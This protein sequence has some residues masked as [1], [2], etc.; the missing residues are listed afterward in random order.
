MMFLMTMHINYVFTRKTILLIV[1]IGLGKLGV[2]LILS[3][4][5]EPA[6]NRILYRDQYAFDYF[7]EGLTMIK[8]TLLILMLYFAIRLFKEAPYDVV[9]VQR[10]NRYKLFLSKWLVLLGIMV[11]W[12][13][14]F[15]SYFWMIGLGVHRSVTALFTADF[16]LKMGV[17]IL[18][19]SIICPL[20]LVRFQH[21]LPL[22]FIVVGFLV[23]DL[24]VDFNKTQTGYGLL[25]TLVN[26]VF[27]NLHVLS[28]ERVDYVFSIRVPLYIMLLA[29]LYGYRRI[30]SLEF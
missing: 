2:F 8:L 14:L 11:V 20:I 24:L 27:L 25:T 22:L 15:L 26:I 23:S 5:Y 17:F 29:M 7:M 10:V 13:F 1:G 18:F 21:L 12:L 16:V 6:V 3:R 30:K 28:L 19:Y 4:F 9:L